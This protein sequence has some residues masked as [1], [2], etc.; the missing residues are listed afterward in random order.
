MNLQGARKTL[1]LTLRAVLDKK[2]ER[3][4]RYL[5]RQEELVKICRKCN[6]KSN[7]SWY[8]EDCTTGLRLHYLDAEFS[9][10]N[11]WWKERD[12]NNS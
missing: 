5:E 11:D 10:V 12:K 8:C 1:C 6:G 4:K 7:G 2:L 3:K 9:D